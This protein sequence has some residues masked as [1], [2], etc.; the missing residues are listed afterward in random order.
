MILFRRFALASALAFAPFAARADAVDYSVTSGAW[1]QVGASGASVWFQAIGGS[2]R[3][4]TSAASPASNATAG[5]EL[6]GTQNDCLVLTQNLWAKGVTGGATVKTETGITCPGGGG[7]GAGTVLVSGTPTSGQI[8]TWTNSTTI[9]GVTALPTSMNIKT[10]DFTIQSAM[11]G[12]VVQINKASAQATALPQAIGAFASGFSVTLEN[13]GA[14]VVTIT[15]TTST[16]NGA[17]SI[18]LAQYDS[19]FV[20]SDG[21][22]YFA[23][24]SKAASGG[25]PAGASLTLQYNNA[26]AFG[27][28]SGTAWD[29]ANQSL[30]ISGATVTT[31]KPVLDLAQTWNAAG[32]VFAGLKFNA[33]RTAASPIS[34]LIDLSINGSNFF[35]V[36]EAYSG[37]AALWLNPSIAPT[38]ANYLILSTGGAVAFNTSQI[39]GSFKFY[40][41]NNTLALTIASPNNGASNVVIGSGSSLATNSTDGFFYASGGAGAPIGVPTAYTG[42]VPMYVDTTNS[43]LWMYLGGAW[44]QP[45]TPAGA[46]L[47]TWQ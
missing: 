47:V 6:L 33:T 11:Q 27:G 25:T 21:A 24:Y 26:G 46:A 2:V 16:I 4:A 37:Y 30:V 12:Q 32:V 38:N 39:N 15:P 36:G 43:Q 1:T 22:N 5:V 14:G 34:R 17:A 7:G 8:A 10:V 41:G 45:K 3:F 35:S 19:V 29:D 40:Q 31:S 20:V 23:M 13:I 18:T 42:S 9:Q 28:M 44:R